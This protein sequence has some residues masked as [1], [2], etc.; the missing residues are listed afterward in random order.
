MAN[1]NSEINIFGEIKQRFL[2][3]FNDPKPAY[4]GYLIVIII[5]IGGLGIWY[6]I[7]QFFNI[8][9]YTIQSV[10]LN[11]STFFMALIASS[12]IDLSIHPKIRNK[13]SL[14]IYS[15]L[16]LGLGMI[17]FFISTTSKND[18]VIYTAII[19]YLLSLF[20]WHISN[21]DNEKLDDEAFNTIIRKEALET[22]GNNWN[23]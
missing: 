8:D 2:M 20:V 5:G 17:L 15:I 16:I 12:F 3:P 13:V 4:F 21:A 19:G 22:H 11:V 14:I 1:N 18:F 6:S 10:S 7:Y 23:N 9:G